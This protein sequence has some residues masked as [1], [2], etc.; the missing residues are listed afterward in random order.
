M[1]SGRLSRA[2]VFAL[3]IGLLMGTSTVSGQTIRPLAKRIRSPLLDA[4]G[5]WINTA[6]PLRLAELRGKIVILDFWTYCCI[7]CMH[8]L[9]ELK[10]LEEAYPN[11]VVVIGVHSPKF[12]TERDTE[13]VREA[14]VREKIAHPVFNDPRRILWQRFDVKVWPSLRVIDPEGYVVAAHAGE[15]TFRELDKLMKPLVSKYRRKRVLD[16]TPLHFA[17][18]AEKRAPT[19]LRYPG[20]V[21][22]DAASDRLF[23]AD[24]YHNRIVI[25]RLD[26]TLVRQIGNGATGRLDGSFADAT[27]DHPQGMA[28]KGSALYIADTEN[29][30]IRK[31]DL[32]TGRVTTVAGTGTQRKKQEV[33]S[34]TRPRGMM[35]ASPWDLLIVGDDLFI[36]MAGSHQIWKMPLDESRIGP[37]AGNGGEDIVDGARLARKPYA[38]GASEFAQPSGL[39]T[40]GRWVFVADSEGSS[41]RAVPLDPKKDVVTVLGT[42]QLKENR[43][44]TFGDRDGNLRTA[45]LQHP[46]GLTFAD[47]IIYVADTYNDKV[48]AIDISKGSVTTLA[49]ERALK[50]AEEGSE[51]QVL[52]EPS[53]VSVAAGKLYIA[54]TNAHR[55][56]V[57]DLDNPTT[58]IATLTIDGLAPPTPPTEK[59][60]PL[61]GATIVK[62]DPVKVQPSDG[63]VKIQLDLALPI[64]FKWNRVAGFQ[65]RIDVAGDEPLFDKKRLAQ[66]ST[67]E[68]DPNQEILLEAPLAANSGS[69]RIRIAAT[70]FYCREGREAVCRIGEVHWIGK[71]DVA[72]DGAKQ[73]NFEHAV[74]T[75]N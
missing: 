65:C 75:T 29:H 31:A 44:F 9:P 11:S 5:D 14:V 4:P 23:I 74:K 39:G 19:P 27:F 67:T 68:Y 47:G 6:G 15:T 50:P 69:D 52:N 3:T 62:F 70:F 36:A 7:N 10:K 57:L 41:I 37:Y 49:G 2:A 45:M 60:S 24:T 54:D 56:R 72:A 43:L 51:N 66:I 55:I 63:V 26:G 30:L 18:E 12:V 25:T 40:D 32:T 33:R 59:W 28:L 38:K 61:P 46:V 64:G 21:L 20:K 73:L 13:N 34:S 22:A 48:R 71:V 17:Q 53:G 1:M 42:A 8:I 35:L 58:P 16:E